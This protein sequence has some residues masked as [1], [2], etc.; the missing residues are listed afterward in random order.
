MGCI[1]DEKLNWDEH[2]NSLTKKLATANSIISKVRYYVSTKNCLDLYYGIFES[3]L[4]YGSI[5]W[6]FTSQ[7]NLKRL[8][9][10][11]KRFL[12]LLYFCSIDDH[13]SPVFISSEILKTEDIFLFETLKFMHSFSQNVIPTALTSLFYYND[14]RC[15]EIK[16]RNLN[17]L[18]TPSFNTISYGKN[19]LSYKGT[20]IWNNFL[21]THDKAHVSSSIK[22]IKRGFK[23]NRLSTYH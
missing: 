19:S 2:I 10:L 8:F 5:V 9:S 16:T 17:L 20:L 14:S 6:Q 13:V 12:K 1:I 18:Y 11:Q 15:S 23:R 3:H 7:K 22:I 21:K 4:T